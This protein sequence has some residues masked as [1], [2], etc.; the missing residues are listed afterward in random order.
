MIFVV[1][2]KMNGNATLVNQYLKN[3]TSFSD[4]LVVCPPFTLLHTLQEFTLGAQN[5]SYFNNGSYTGE[6]SAAMLKE[7]G[8]SYVIVGHSERRSQESD[9]IVLEKAKRAIEQGITPIICCSEFT[10]I[11]LDPALYWIA[12]E[13]LWAIGTGKT[14]TSEEINKMVLSFKQK[15]GVKTVLYGGSVNANNTHLFTQVC[16]GFLIGGASLKIDEM[17]IILNQTSS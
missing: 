14:P 6:I 3:L 15:T 10:N 7:A 1:N 8:C 9:A 11:D 16:D 13:P 17:K 5:C 2:W 12:Y 4:K